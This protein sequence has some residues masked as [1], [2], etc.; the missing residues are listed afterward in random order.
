MPRISIIRSQSIEEALGSSDRQYLV[1]ALERPQQLDHTHDPSVEIGISDYD[2]AAADVPHF[3]PVAS[4]HQYVV[5][6][7]ALLRDLGTGVIH[8]LHAGDFYS[9]GPNVAHVQ[10][11]SAGTRIVFFRH[12]GG[13][14]KVLIEPDEDLDAWLKDLEF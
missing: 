6:G 2:A 7:Y 5:S 14:A 10:K 8:E 11:S 13:D 1:G 4:E 12:P 3:H 9:I